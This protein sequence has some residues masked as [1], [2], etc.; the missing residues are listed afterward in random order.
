MKYYF[1]VIKKYAVFSGRAR[2]S[3]FWY[4]TLFST[5][6][7]LVLNG[8]TLQFFPA[9]DLDGIYTLLIILPSIAVG[10][11]RMHDVGLSGW[12]YIIPFYSLFIA[13]QPSDFCDNQYGPNPIYGAQENIFGEKLDDNL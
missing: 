2:R 7:S 8:I 5:I 13:C 1:E 10:V 12:Y 3:E 11:R 9:I 4:F 6:I